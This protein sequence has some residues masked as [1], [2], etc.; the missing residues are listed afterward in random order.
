[1]VH[2]PISS[3]KGHTGPFTCR[4]TETVH[5]IL[6][7]PGPYHWLHDALPACAWWTPARL[8]MVRTPVDFR[9][10]RRAKYACT[11]RQLINRLE[12]HRPHMPT[13][14]APDSNER[15]A[16]PLRSPPVGAETLGD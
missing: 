12:R 4:W 7:P 10:P 5:P 8:H 13:C 16:S 3:V 15:Q 9:S 6:H 11:S 2:P 1:M 14:F